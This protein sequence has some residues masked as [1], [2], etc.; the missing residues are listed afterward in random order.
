LLTKKNVGIYNIAMLF[1][2][3]YG[4]FGGYLSVQTCLSDKQKEQ[5]KTKR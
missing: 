2:Y 3:L 5:Y 1:L 4:N